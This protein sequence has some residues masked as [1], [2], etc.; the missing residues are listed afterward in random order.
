MIGVLAKITAILKTWIT[1][2]ENCLVL[3]RVL[4]TNITAAAAA[5]APDF[6]KDIQDIKDNYEDDFKAYNKLMEEVAKKPIV[7]KCCLREGMRDVLD[8]YRTNFIQHRLACKKLLELK[9]KSLPRL[10]F[11]SDKEA[12]ILLGGLSGVRSVFQQVACKIFGLGVTRIHFETVGAG[13]S[14]PVSAAGDQLRVSHIES[15]NGEQLPVYRRVECS[16]TSTD[17]WLK[18]LIEEMKVGIVQMANC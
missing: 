13:S 7:S 11:L 16:H 4:L 14:D 10:A 5:S 1:T 15:V 12:L 2:Q 8:N 9:Q 6:F 3:A 17:L 18:K